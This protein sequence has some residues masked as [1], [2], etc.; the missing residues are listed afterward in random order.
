[1][2]DEMEGSFRTMS[3]VLVRSLHPHLRTTVNK[4]FILLRP[5]AV[6]LAR[7]S[8]APVKLTPVATSG[9]S[10]RS[11][12]IDK[13][14]VLNHPQCFLLTA[15][16]SAIGP[17]SQ[18]IKAGPFVFLSGVIPVHAETGEVTEGGIEEQTVSIKKMP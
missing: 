11:T 12:P 10:L 3:R 2:L 8:S 17:Y 9:V 5:P 14:I 16:P 7:M 15:A 4:S 1:M 18:A 6:P 13:P